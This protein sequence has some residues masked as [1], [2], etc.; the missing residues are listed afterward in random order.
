[1][2][3][4]IFGFQSYISGTSSYDLP[5]DYN[6]F[7]GR[8]NEDWDVYWTET[9]TSPQRVPLPQGKLQVRFPSGIR[10]TPND[11]ITTGLVSQARYI[12]LVFNLRQST[13]KALGKVQHILTFLSI[14]YGVFTKH[15][16]SA[17]NLF[18]R[19]SY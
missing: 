12:S 18:Y 1:M 2:H 11:T 9:E 8:A 6:R 5:S 14:M 3:H 4:V 19:R 16:T 7:V 17:L 10:V 13:P 15:T